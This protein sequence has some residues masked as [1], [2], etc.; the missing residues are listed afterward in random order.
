MNVKPTYATGVQVS[1]AVRR[2]DLTV[3][4]VQSF[5][6]IEGLRYCAKISL[7]RGKKFHLVPLAANTHFFVLCL[8]GLHAT[9]IFLTS[10]MDSFSDIYDSPPPK[11]DVFFDKRIMVSRVEK[12]LLTAK[13]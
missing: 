8:S 4:A 9:F 2:T 5:S 12:D 6:T 3:S 7:L 10:T 1:T 13:R 11:A